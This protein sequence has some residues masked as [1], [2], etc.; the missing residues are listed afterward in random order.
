MSGTSGGLLIDADYA[1]TLSAF[2]K[3]LKKNNI[4]MADITYILE[5]HY[6]PNHIGLV[7]ELTKMG[8]KL[9]LL[10]TQYD[11]VH[12]AD[13]I[14][15]RERHLLYEPIDENKAVIITCSESRDFLANIGIVGEI[16][17]T[18]AIV[19]KVYLSFWT[20]ENVWLAI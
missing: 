20:M 14:F 19:R 9:L 3:V 11:Y 5:T 16:I 15:K 4:S 17:T 6:Q 2:Y 13:S 18:Q 8:I 10:D 12:F 1:G 7:S